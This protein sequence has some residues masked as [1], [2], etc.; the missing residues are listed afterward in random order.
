[1]AL[2]VSTMIVLMK[3]RSFLPKI[4]FGVIVLGGLELLILARLTPEALPELELVAPE[5]SQTGVE[6]TAMM[7]TRAHPSLRRFRSLVTA[8]IVTLFE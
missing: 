1:M 4:E 6:I 8:S 7:A 3:G 2:L 5:G